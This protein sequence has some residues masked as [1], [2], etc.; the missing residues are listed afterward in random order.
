MP[1]P[2]QIKVDQSGKPPGVPGRAREDLA[3]GTAVQ[4]AAVGGPFVTYLWTLAFKPVDVV[5]GARSSAALS[6]ATTSTTLVQPIDKAGTYRVGIAVDAGFG[7]G[8]REQD[9]AFITFYAG[10][11]LSADPTQYPRR[12]PAVGETIEHNVPDAIDPGGNPDG[13]ARERARWDAAQTAARTPRLLEVVSTHAD[14]AALA[15]GVKTHAYLLGGVLPAGAVILILPTIPA[16]VGFDDPTHAEVD[17]AVGTTIGGH[18][19][20]GSP[21]AVDVTNG[22][23]YPGKFYSAGGGFLGQRIGGVQLYVTVS[24]AI[25]LRTI[26][27]GTMTF[28][29]AYF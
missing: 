7:L 19:L 1:P 15:P 12:E 5:A 14:F 29:L 25:D 10:P 27:A 18:Q 13:W 23:G 26:T 4:L 24:S 17:A 9:V 16:W 2:L 11:A 21:F 22:G 3:L 6:S 28:S 8:A 20:S